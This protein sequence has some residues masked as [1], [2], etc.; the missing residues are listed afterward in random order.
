MPYKIFL[1]HKHLSM[2]TK[3]GI[4]KHVWAGAFFLV[5]FSCKKSMIQDQA[6]LS[7]SSGKQA[8]ATTL[9]NPTIYVA[10]SQNSQAV[11]WKDDGTGIV[12][13][14]LPGGT[15]ATG[16]QVVGTDVH[17][18]G[19]Y[20]DPST[21]NRIALYWLNGNA[22]ALTSGG[23]SGEIWATGITVTTSGDVYITG[24][25]GRYARTAVYWLNGVIH[26]LS[27]GDLTG[28]VSVASNGDVYLPDPN[29]NS[30]WK[31]GV[32]NTLNTIPGL[33]SYN[34]NALALDANTNVYVVGRVYPGP[35]K[36]AMYWKNNVP[37][38]LTPNVG[39][40][41]A[42]DVI[43]DGYGISHISGTGGAINDERVGVWENG[44]PGFTQWG[45]KRF[46]GRS[47]IDL[48]GSD[49]YVCGGEYDDATHLNAKYWFNGI[50]INLTT[51]S[52]AAYGLDIDVVP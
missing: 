2:K 47:R 6:D 22:T 17:V 49:I 24:Y 44:T 19:L 46:Y 31:N 40:F 20:S 21:G 5:L 7:V 3:T 1:N 13:T 32:I 28:P 38:Q 37:T 12:T 8:R 9:T 36:I 18:C 23:L 45:T 27:G 29:S 10:G 4:L 39:W 11:Y 26:T 15:E 30:Y 41:E 52:V 33:N 51:G 43:V 25:I 35:N 14:F 48:I 42:H 50:P 34:A 16:I